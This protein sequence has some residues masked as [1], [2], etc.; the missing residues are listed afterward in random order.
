MDLVVLV[1][2]LF[3]TLVSDGIAWVTVVAYLVHAIGEVVGWFTGLFVTSS[4]FVLD[5]SGV[6]WETGCISSTFVFGSSGVVWGI[7]GAYPHI[8]QHVLTCPN[9]SSHILTY[10]HISS[11][12][13]TCP[14]MS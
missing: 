11:H 13:P 4:A 1:K 10:P 14:H 2:P 7:V 5:L 8:S 9:I 3:E 12:I 6:V